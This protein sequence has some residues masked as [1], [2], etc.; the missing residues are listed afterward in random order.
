LVHFF[1]TAL[2]HHGA[3]NLAPHAARAISD[4]FLVFNIIV[5]ITLEL[6]NK[7]ARGSRIR[8][9]SIFKFTN[10]RFVS[11]SPIEKHY[12]IAIGLDQFIHFLRL[13]MLTT[14]NHS[15]FIDFKLIIGIFKTN[16]LPTGLDAHSR[17]V[18][19][20]TIRP[21]KHGIP[22]PRVLFCRPNVSL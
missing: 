12:V 21:L 20:S 10:L 5:F 13:K 22:E 11:V 9:N 19:T 7:V 18:F 1:K 6:S 2:F 15:I 17:K 8:H 3:N 16:K 14:A 4:D